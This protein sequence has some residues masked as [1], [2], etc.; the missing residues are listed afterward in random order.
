M[1]KIAYVT[2]KNVYGEDRYYPD[3]EKSRALAEIAGTKTLT[4]ATMNQAFRLGLVF[5]SRTRPIN[6]VVL[7]RTFRSS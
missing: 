5:E 6:P 7:N 3:C 4:T 2:V 1:K